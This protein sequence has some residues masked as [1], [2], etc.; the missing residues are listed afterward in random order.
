MKKQKIETMKKYSTKILEVT[1]VTSQ[2]KHLV[3]ITAELR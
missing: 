3:N 1:N 2:I